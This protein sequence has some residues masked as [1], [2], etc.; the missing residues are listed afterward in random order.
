M[1]W[2]HLWFEKV[3]GRFHGVPAVERRDSSW[4]RGR[5]CGVNMGNSKLTS[6][7]SLVFQEIIVTVFSETSEVTFNS[8][9]L[10]SFNSVLQFSPLQ[11]I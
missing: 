1:F 2:S 11:G 10:K 4:C 6:L 5:G 9:I 8:F 3:V 7:I